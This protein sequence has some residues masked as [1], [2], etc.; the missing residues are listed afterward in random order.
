MKSFKYQYLRLI[1]NDDIFQQILDLTDQYVDYEICKTEY[2]DGENYV[3]RDNPDRNSKA[4]FID[5]P[6]LYELVD[7]LTRFANEECKWNYD[8]DF[9][10]PLQHTLYEVGGFY[11]WHID[12]SNWLP[13]KRPN[14][15]IRKISFSLV[16]N[17]DFTGGEFEIQTNEINTIE[18][19]KGEIIFFNG[20]TQHRVKPVESG[21]RR[22]LVGWIQ[23][24]PYR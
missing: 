13:G 1:L 10:E 24:P 6:K 16:L 8:I 11:D 4:C 19:K 7:G 17:D 21:I 22:S 14:N 20:D 12:E 18:L 2:H 3:S 23:G 9:I 15:K 5:D